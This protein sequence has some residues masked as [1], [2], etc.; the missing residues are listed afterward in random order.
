[1]DGLSFII[2]SL[3]RYCERTWPKMR[4]E[5][6]IEAVAQLRKVFELVFSRERPESKDDLDDFTDTYGR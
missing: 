3:P 2:V 4:I 6:C 5:I 1:M